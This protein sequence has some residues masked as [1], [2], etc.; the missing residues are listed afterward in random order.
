MRVKHAQKVYSRI[1]TKNQ[2]ASNH[3][4]YYSN[5]NHTVFPED[6]RNLNHTVFPEDVR[7]SNHTVFPEDVRNLNHTV[8]PEDV[9]NLNHTVFPEDVRNLNH[10]VFW[11]IHVYSDSHKNMS[12]VLENDDE[13]N[14]I[15]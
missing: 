1:F 6:V 15:C 14:E 3:R 10:T 5:L 12:R 8:F 4:L 7:N 2:Y 9:R 11:H 13:C